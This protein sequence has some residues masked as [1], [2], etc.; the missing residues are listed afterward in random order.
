[1]HRPED[2]RSIP[3]NASILMMWHNIPNVLIVRPGRQFRITSY[4]FSH[5]TLQRNHTY[6]NRVK[7]FLCPQEHL[8]TYHIPCSLEELCARFCH[9]PNMKIAH[10]DFSS[11][12]AK[13]SLMV[14][15]FVIY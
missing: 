5:A 7:L 15:W 14:K 11:A 6:I 2:E 12:K 8:S 10:A 3:F 1:M 13:F 9:L 4:P